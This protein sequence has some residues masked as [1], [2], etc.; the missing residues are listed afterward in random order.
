MA[1]VALMVCPKAPQP[2]LGPRAIRHEFGP[3][4]SSRDLPPRLQ[5]HRCAGGRLIESTKQKDSEG[6]I[7]VLVD[8]L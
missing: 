2:S 7:R 1:D 5:G 4:E 6:L 8:D 3:P